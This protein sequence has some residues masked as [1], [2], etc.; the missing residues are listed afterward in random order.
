MSTKLL[1]LWSC[2]ERI[3]GLNQFPGI[4]S[5]SCKQSWTEICQRLLRDKIFLS[6]QGFYLLISLTFD[7]PCKANVHEPA[8]YNF[9]S[10]WLVTF[11]SHCFTQFPREET[12]II[13]GKSHPLASTRV[14]LWVN[15]R[16]NKVNLPVLEVSCHNRSIIPFQTVI[17]NCEE[18]QRLH[19]QDV[20]TGTELCCSLHTLMDLH[21]AVKTLSNI[22]QPRDCNKQ[23]DRSVSA[24]C[25]D[26]FVREQTRRTG[27][28]SHLS[29]PLSQPC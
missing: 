19:E 18:R 12:R 17:T 14:F 11:L 28:R 6:A 4:S 25:D 23:F 3:Y 16:E 20:L 21:R 7:I 5:W 1:A 15:A 13:L 22:M 27:G 29:G 2:L 26:S 9:V 10:I 8:I 24:Q